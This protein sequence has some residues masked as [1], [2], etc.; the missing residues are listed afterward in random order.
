MKKKMNLLTLMIFIELNA[1]GIFLYFCGVLGEQQALFKDAKEFKPVTIKC[2]AS[3]KNQYRT[4]KRQ[5][6][7]YEN[8]YEYLV[9]EKT[10]TRVYYAE[11]TPGKD[12]LMYYNP[13]NPEILSEYS[14]YSTAVIDNFGWILLSALAQGIVVVYALRVVKKMNNNTYLHDAT[15]S[16]GVVLEDDYEFILNQANKPNE[17]RTLEREKDYNE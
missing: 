5:T 3:E 17:Q 10:Y 7:W 2:V 14:S 6:T 8:T 13:N 16:V 15:Q 1:I 12:K 11:N 4:V 9:N